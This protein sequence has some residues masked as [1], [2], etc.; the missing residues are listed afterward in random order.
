M[1]K[2]DDEEN[3]T[4]ETNT[5]ESSNKTTHETKNI[6]L[7]Y[8]NIEGKNIDNIFKSKINKD[9]LFQ[10]LISKAVSL[11]T[12]QNLEKS[13]ENFILRKSTNMACYKKIIAEKK[14]PI[15]DD[16]LQMSKIKSILQ[17]M[18]LKD[19][20]ILKKA[21]IKL[22]LNKFRFKLKFYFQTYKPSEK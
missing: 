22:F 3:C 10:S 1:K 9:N 19:N 7:L 8:K 21:E 17:N 18:Q 4:K 12:K 16:K 20:I 5:N 15:N 6:G 11:E 14:N 13:K 2:T